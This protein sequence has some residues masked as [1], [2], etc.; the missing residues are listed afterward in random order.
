M[1]RVTHRSASRLAALTA[2]T[3]IVAAC[4]G[5]AVPPPPSQPTAAPAA[6]AAESKPAAQPTAAPAAAKSTEAPKPT[7]QPAA[8]KKDTVV[9]AQSSTGA[10][11]TTL[12]MAGVT[13]WF[14]EAFN[15]HE[16]LV[17]LVFD[18][19]QVQYKPGIAESW[20]IVD[21]RTYEFKIR[22]GVK[23]HNG[24]TVTAS[25]VAFSLNRIL[26]KDNKLAALTYFQYFNEAKVVDDSTVVITT[27]DPYA[28]AIPR[29]T[30]LT[31]VPEKVV[32]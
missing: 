29:L 10:N 32:K 1:R 4:S 7:A 21:D 27:R 9:I 13:G 25:D 22:K 14:N 23:F 11:A 15:I 5:Q 17:K 30:F 12:D 16:P 6:K 3:L 2:L 24:D 26:D 31:I 19:D 18:G 28:P 20:R 8:L